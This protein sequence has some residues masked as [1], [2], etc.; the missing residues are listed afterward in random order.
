[1]FQHAVRTLKLRLKSPLGFTQLEGLNDASKLESTDGSDDALGMTVLW[2]A[3]WGKTCNLKRMYSILH[4]D[5]RNV[6]TGFHLL[7]SETFHQ[8]H[9]Y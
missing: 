5:H 9:T 3:E 7:T 8:Y 2:I 1:M 4:T 6:S